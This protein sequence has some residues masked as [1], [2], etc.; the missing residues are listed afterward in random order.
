MLGTGTSLYS[1]G[2]PNGDGVVAWPL[3]DL[4]AENMLQLDDTFVQ[5][6]GYHNPQ[7]DYLTTLPQP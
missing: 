3:Y 1:T 4:N 5:I 2:N 6:S 7:C